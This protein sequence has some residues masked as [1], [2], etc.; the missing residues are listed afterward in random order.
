VCP[1]G[2]GGT[3]TWLPLA[4]P[5]EFT[6]KPAVLILR[7]RCRRSIEEDRA[8]DTNYEISCSIVEIYNEVRPAE[9]VACISRSL[10]CI[11]QCVAG[12]HH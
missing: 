7:L 5:A 10:Q 1:T 3:D 2:K 8:T 12:Q 11:E 4:G 9:S 6:G